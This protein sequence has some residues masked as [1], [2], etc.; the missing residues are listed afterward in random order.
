MKG[1]ERWLIT[2]LLVALIAALVGLWHFA[3]QNMI[4][5]H[6]TQTEWADIYIKTYSVLGS[7]IYSANPNYVSINLGQAD[8]QIT[9]TPFYP[10]ATTNMRCSYPPTEDKL[11]PKIITC[12][13]KDISVTVI[14][15]SP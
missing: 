4:S 13:G 3:T 14:K 12:F 10:S 7:S 8:V 1:R 6:R 2:T 5:T 11:N 9:R 15:M